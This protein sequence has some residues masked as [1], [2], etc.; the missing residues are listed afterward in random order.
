[1]ISRLNI[2]R[3]LSCGKGELKSQGRS[4]EDSDRARG[5]KQVFKQAVVNQSH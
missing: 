4:A 1:M 3:P 5:A 2:T